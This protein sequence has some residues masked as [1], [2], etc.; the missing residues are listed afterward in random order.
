M[1][2]R[3]LSLEL[4]LVWILM[5]CRSATMNEHI[6]LLCSLIL[7]TY[8]SWPLGQYGRLL[9]EVV[10]RH[11][12]YFLLITFIRFSVCSKE[13]WKLSSD[14]ALAMYVVT[15]GFHEQ[16][17]LKTSQALLQMLN[18]VSVIASGLMI[19]KG[20][21]LLCNTESP[22]VVVLRYAWYT[23]CRGITCNTDLMQN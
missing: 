3:H 6:K 9:I 8:A 2:V 15:R 20:L 17:D 18:F 5:F 13:N 1:F 12:A 22:I 10:A 21:G 19:W 7:T 11:L 14:L 23:R 16:V 4:N